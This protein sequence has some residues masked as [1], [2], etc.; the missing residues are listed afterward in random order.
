MIWRNLIGTLKKNRLVSAVLCLTLCCLCCLLFGTS[1]SSAL[2][3][4]RSQT[5][6]TTN[7]TSSAGQ[8]GYSTYRNGVTSFPDNINSSTGQ[9][10]TSKV[11]SAPYP[12]GY[13]A[14]FFETNDEYFQQNNAS[15]HL[16]YNI[17]TAEY[18]QRVY[19]L[20][21]D[22]SHA[23][24]LRVFYCNR[25]IASQNVSYYLTNWTETLNIGGNL[26]FY[27]FQTTTLY[28]DIVFKSLPYGTNGGITCGVGINDGNTLWRVYEPNGGFMYIEK[29]EP[30]IQYF[31]SLDN[32]LQKATNNALQQQ[33]E[34]LEWQRQAEI[35][36]QQRELERQQQEEADRAN[37]E[38]VSG[39]STGDGNNATS[40]ARSATSNLIQSISTIYGTFLNPSVTNCDI[41]PINIYDQLNLGTLNF[42]ASFPM[43]QPILAICGLCGIGI[44]LLLA[45]SVLHSALSLYND[46]F[47]GK[48]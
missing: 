11:W 41:G 22:T 2:S 20:G 32:A 27:A 10:N 8:W 6:Y 36:R 35:E 43:P 33:T 45:W 24:D 23:S 28:I 25:D 46:L 40:S 44:I 39:D 3:L 38:D 16:E 12:Y 26:Y 18:G 31:A 14:I 21:F 9:F 7:W 47:G 1:R 19:D 4:N 29:F 13:D 17:V 34:I 30:T 42:C 15:L 5:H 37:L 48:G